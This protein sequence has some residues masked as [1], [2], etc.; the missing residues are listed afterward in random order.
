MVAEAAKENNQDPAAQVEKYRT[1]YRSLVEQNKS[2]TDE[3]KKV[4]LAW[5]E[6][7]PGS[8]DLKALKDRIDHFKQGG[9]GGALNEAV[10][11]KTV[12]YR[13]IMDKLKQE[14]AIRGETIKDR[15]AWFEKLS[16]KEKAEILNTLDHKRDDAFDPKRKATHDAFKKLVS[17]FGNVPAYRE[18]LGKEQKDRE[19]MLAEFTEKKKAVSSGVLPSIV[20]GKLRIECG[21]VDV[22]ACKKMMSEAQQKHAELKARYLKLPPLVQE[23]HKKELK[24]KQLPER[25]A[26]IGKLEQEIATLTSQYRGKIRSMQQPNAHGLTLFSNVPENV[27]GSSA[28]TYM[29]HFEQKLTLKGMRDFVDHDDLD[30]PRRGELVTTMGTEILP[31]MKPTEQ[32]KAIAD[33]NR[34]DLDG[35]QG[36]EGREQMVPKLRAITGAASSTESKGWIQ[37]AIGR[38]LRSSK[39]SEID[40]KFQTWSVVNEVAERRKRFKLVKHEREDLTQKAAE[41]G[42]DETLRRTFAFEAATRLET[43]RK[44][45]G[46]VKVKLDPLE[47]HQDARESWRRVLKQDVDDPNAK[48]AGDVE[49]RTK[50]GDLVVDERQYQKGE[51][52]RELEEVKKDLMPVLEAEAVTEGVAFDAQ[53]AQQVL[54]DEDWQTHGKEEIRKGA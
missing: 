25:E 38:L 48:L 9:T 12:Q 37:K 7:D 20:R 15:I 45:D 43:L 18:F 4:C 16:F 11:E 19:K 40:K 32:N 33:F 31:R 2:L 42:Q 21:K 50:S 10:V 8:R 54:E 49:L 47:T 14:G 22:D 46:G 44:E 17:Y 41:H 34:A 29:N 3:D 39:H 51:L 1:E 27:P 52:Q 13:Q 26:F 28:S 36:K 53:T 35:S 24:E 30:N 6:T 23:E 5:L